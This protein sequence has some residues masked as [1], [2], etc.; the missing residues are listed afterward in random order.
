MGK[1]CVAH[2]IILPALAATIGGNK[3]WEGRGEDIAGHYEHDYIYICGCKYGK[4]LVNI[5]LDFRMFCR[6]NAK[7]HILFRIKEIL[8]SCVQ[9]PVFL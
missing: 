6:P 8:F 7:V 1:C 2:D 3:L 4:L 5:E 9:L